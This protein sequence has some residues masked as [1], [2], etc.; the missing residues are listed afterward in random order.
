MRQAG[1]IG[2]M[3]AALCLALALLLLV[4]YHSSRIAISL[5]GSGFAL[6]GAVVTK[7]ANAVLVPA[8]GLCAVAVCRAQRMSLREAVPMQARSSP[9]SH[10]AY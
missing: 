8:F 1:T 10:F 7:P 3:I 6:A 9:R 5:L 2:T 4:Q